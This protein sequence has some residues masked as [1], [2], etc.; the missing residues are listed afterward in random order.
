MK[1]VSR[2]DC[3]VARGRATLRFVPASRSAVLSPEALDSLRDAA[4][5]LEAGL[6]LVVLEGAREDL[7]SPGADLT[8]LGALEPWSVPEFAERGRQAFLAFSRIPALTVAVVRGPCFGGALD[9]VLSADVVVALPAARFAHPGV[10]RGI[11]TGWG[12]TLTA[13][14]RLAG[15]DLRRLFLE[16]EVLSA[17][18]ALDCGLVDAVVPDDADDAALEALL[19]RLEGP[20]GRT[21]LGLCGAAS[22]LEGLSPALAIQ[23]EERMDELKSIPAT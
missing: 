9:L 10:R 20:A 2:F 5:G 22:L 4:E 19:V 15:A 11:V 21:L 3:T 14:R 8:S 17:E 18:V 1:A 7:F 16:A 12:G 23:L 6:D 13:S